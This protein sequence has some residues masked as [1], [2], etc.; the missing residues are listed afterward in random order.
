MASSGRHKSMISRN[1]EIS[2][3]LSLL[4]APLASLSPTGSSLPAAYAGMYFTM[5][6]S[7][8]PDRLGRHLAQTP[9]G[10]HA[11]DETTQTSNRIAAQQVSDA[12]AVLS[13]SRSQ[14][15]QVFSNNDPPLPVVLGQNFNVVS[16][17]TAQASQVSSQQ[18]TSSSSN[19][20]QPNMLQYAIQSN[21]PQTNTMQSNISQEV[22]H[23][24][25]PVIQRSTSEPEY[26]PSN[27]I[28]QS[29]PNQF[30]GQ[31]DVRPSFGTNNYATSGREISLSTG[32]QSTNSAYIRQPDNIMNTMNDPNS[33][34]Q[35]DIQ[36]LSQGSGIPSLDQSFVLIQVLMN[37]RKMLVPLPQDMVMSDVPDVIEN[38]YY[39]SEL[40]SYSGSLRQ[41]VTQLLDEYNV[42][43]PLTQNILVKDLLRQNQ[44]IFVANVQSYIAEEQMYNMEA[45]QD[46]PPDQIQNA[47]FLPDI[48]TPPPPPPPVSA[49]SQ[50]FVGE[51][52]YALKLDVHEDEPLATLVSIK[53]HCDEL[54]DSAV[55]GGPQTSSSQFGNFVHGIELPTGEWKCVSCDRILGSR[56]AVW[57]HE[58]NMH[59]LPTNHQCGY[60]HKYL[61]GPTKLERHV[62]LHLGIKEFACERCD[63]HLSTQRQLDM[64]YRIHGNDP[65]F[66]CK[67]FGRAF[68]RTSNLKSHMRTHTGEKPFAC[69]LCGRKFAH[70][71]VLQRHQRT[72]TGETPYT[73]PQCFK[74]FKQQSNLKVH[75]KNHQDARIFRC[76]ICGKTFTENKNLLDH[77]KVHASD[78]KMFRCPHCT[79]TFGEYDTMKAHIDS[80]HVTEEMLPP[81]DVLSIESIR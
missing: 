19:A 42:E 43:I 53:K 52:P 10:H 38:E 28:H 44:T 8:S 72:H 1:L 79:H 46:Y 30:T 12:G 9:V 23:F 17:D 5:G 80:C 74:A 69:E 64:H 75:M 4:D 70:K 16:D 68:T 61:T 45:P 7:S 58:V 56:R 2:E 27:S 14:L 11:Q 51:P 71:F 65:K 81:V 48:S 26:Y 33:I 35:E 40:V 54:V 3:S 77:L 6:P 41:R 22:N 66:T 78:E 29:M 76:N 13:I 49:I 55:R 32:E 73:C 50:G 62:R 21:H 60:C 36:L 18:F 39:R 67:L 47:N 63:A 24:N 37:E 34:P 20:T 57:R 15:T 25:Q 31:E 59:Q